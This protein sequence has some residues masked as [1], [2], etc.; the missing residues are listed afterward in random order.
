MI[1]G[2]DM[3]LIESPVMADS[4]LPDLLLPKALQI[5]HC[6]S[7]CTVATVCVTVFFTVCVTVYTVYVAITNSRCLLGD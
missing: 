2:K 6:V 7:H 4:C 3:F 1:T 5:M